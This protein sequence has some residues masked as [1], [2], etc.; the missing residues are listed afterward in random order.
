MFSCCFLKL[1]AGLGVE[2]SIAEVMSLAWLSVSTHPP[3]CLKSLA[4]EAGLEPPSGRLEC[5]CLL[6]ATLVSHVEKVLCFQQTLFAS[7]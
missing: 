5:P 2:P 6:L 4:P 1:V 3:C 7:H